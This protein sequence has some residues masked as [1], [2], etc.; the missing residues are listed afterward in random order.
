MLVDVRS[1]QT[2][3]RRDTH[4][5]KK[6][7]YSDTHNSCNFDGGEPK[8]D[9]TVSS[10]VEHIETKWKYREDRYPN[11]TIDWGPWWHYICNHDEFR[12]ESDRETAVNRIQLM[13]TQ[14]NIST[15]TQTPNCVRKAW[16]DIQEKDSKYD[17]PVQT[18][19]QA[20]EDMTPF[21][22]VWSIIS[23]NLMHTT[24]TAYMTVPI[25][26]YE[27]QNNIGPPK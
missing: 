22:Q 23:M 6:P 13:F 8:F 14:A 26:M 7:Q 2:S 9:F 1:V 20:M 4:W 11:R 24:I 10:D 12:G 25:T 17:L 16:Q 19:H 27:R 5:H 21:P 15:R 18:T 3:I